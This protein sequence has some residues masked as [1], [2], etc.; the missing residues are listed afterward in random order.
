M[1]TTHTVIP[2]ILIM[3][4]NLYQCIAQLDAIIPK[5]DTIPA[6]L[7]SVNNTSLTFIVT[8]N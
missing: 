5:G 6:Q 2:P 4:E 8:V 3:N 7:P 1:M